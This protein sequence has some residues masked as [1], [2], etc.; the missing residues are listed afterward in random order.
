MNKIENLSN[1]V[2]DPDFVDCPVIEAP[3]NLKNSYK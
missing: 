2:I 1:I 3:K